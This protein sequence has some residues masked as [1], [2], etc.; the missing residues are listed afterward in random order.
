P[1]SASTTCSRSARC[2][3]CATVACPPPRTSRSSGSTTSR[4]AASPRPRSARSHPTSGAWPR[5]RSTCCS[6]CATTRRRA[7]PSR[8]TGSW[9]ARRR[10]APRP[11]R[12]EQRGTTMTETTGAALPRASEQDGTYPRPQLVRPRWADLA[13]AWD[14][15]TDPD[16]VGGDEGWWD[17]GPTR[18]AGGDPFDRTITVPFPPESQASGIG[19]TSPQRVVWYRR[20]LTPAD[21]EA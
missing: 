8:R 13:G 6:A 14:F 21:L 2:A 15:A 3:P 16:D 4:R 20:A 12:D 7:R 17:P 10:R 18:G 9:R 19:D 1:S 5:P 11:D